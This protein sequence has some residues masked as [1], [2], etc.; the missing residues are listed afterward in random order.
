MH[1]PRIIHAN[2]SALRTLYSEGW[3]LVCVSDGK[4][5]LEREIRVTRAQKKSVR[6]PEY[7]EFHDTYPKK[8]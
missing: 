2:D 1:E 8:A 5:Y 7:Q 3:R 6:T 4:M